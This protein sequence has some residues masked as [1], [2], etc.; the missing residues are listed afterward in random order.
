MSFKKEIRKIHV[1][2]RMTVSHFT[3]WLE[4]ECDGPEA[5]GFWSAGKGK[6]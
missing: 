3:P 1:F 6:L 2:S 4:E 5:A